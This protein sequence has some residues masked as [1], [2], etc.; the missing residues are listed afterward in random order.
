[1]KHKKKSSFF[2]ASIIFL[3]LGITG[4]SQITGNSEID[5][6]K[7][8]EVGVQV[9]GLFVNSIDA[10]DE[11]F[12]RNGFPERTLNDKFLDVGIGGRFTYN[13][14]RN[15]AIETEINYF[16]SGPTINELASSGNSTNVPFSGGKKTQFLAGLKYGIRRNK[17][18]VFGKIRPGAIRFTGYP[19]LT[20]VII[21]PSPSG[22]RPDDVITFANE[23]AALLFNI[24]IGGVFEYYPTK[25]T[26]FRVDVGDTIIRYN[27]QKPKNINPTFNRHNL[28]TSIGFG[29]RF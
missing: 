29:F 23:K 16:P 6:S 5:E 17:F 15:L 1:M 12:R 25:N 26:V 21:I 2:F 7:K 24:D 11:I 18:G 19:R 27:A 28:Q 20:N 4:L 14:N 10:S 3:F 13:V 8:L 22:G 9:S